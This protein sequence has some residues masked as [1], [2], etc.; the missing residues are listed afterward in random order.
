VNN[1]TWTSSKRKNYGGSITWKTWTP[2]T[3]AFNAD[4]YSAN[5]YLKNKSSSTE[6]VYFSST[7]TPCTTLY[8]TGKDEGLATSVKAWKAVTNAL[9]AADKPSSVVDA[10]FEKKDMYEAIIFSIF[11]VDSES[12]ST[13]LSKL[14]EIQDNSSELLKYVKAGMKLKFNIDITENYNLSQLTLVQKESLFSMANEWFTDN[15]PILKKLN[16]GLDISELALNYATAFS[17]WCKYA[18]SCAALMDLSLSEKQVLSSMYD[19]AT[20]SN[21]K[22]ALKECVSVMDSSQDKY[23]KA[24]MK[25]FGTSMTTTTIKTALDKGWDVVKDAVKSSNPYAFLF[26]TSYEG[27]TTLCKKLFSTDKI[28]EQFCKMEAIVETE[29]LLRKVYNLSKKT[30]NNSKTAE[31]AAVLNSAVTI[32]Y[33][34]IDLD[35]QYAYNFVDTVDKAAWSKFL[36]VFSAKDHAG[37]LKSIQN[38]RCYSEDFYYTICD[39]W[40]ISIKDSYPLAYAVY[41]NQLIYAMRGAAVSLSASSYT[42]TG[43]TIKPSLTV[44]YASKK[45]TNGTDYT[46]KFSNNTKVGTATITITGKGNYTGTTTATFKINPTKTSLSSVSN[47][48]TKAMT[49]KWKKNLTG[50]GYEIQYST[51]SDFSSGTKTATVK[52]N[53][54]I[55]KKITGLTKNKT[56]YVRIR[57]YKT[58]SNKKYYSG[59]SSVKKVK[60]SK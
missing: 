10:T 19:N 21:L 4:I 25:K 43:K 38:I 15:H 17:D 28:S 14:T 54:T 12:D 23:I 51:K 42:Y 24:M 34:C 16:T 56:Y 41:K 50:D 27:S 33:S 39:D 53:A 40:I 18:E 49:V 9:S 45:L 37:L 35:C 48:K 31:N 22:A 30:Y 32:I 26:W 11:K 57:T 1:S 60:I 36:R 6:N 13:L 58:V 29:T 44:K 20:N 2:V 3:D 55:S 5:Y 47:T 8:N 52:K 59:W 7:A 46:V